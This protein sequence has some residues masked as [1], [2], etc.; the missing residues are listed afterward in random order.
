MKS[1]ERW[2]IF[3]WNLYGQRNRFYLPSLEKR[4]AFL[5]L[6]IG[7]WETAWRKE[8]GSYRQGIALS[9]ILTRIFCLAEFL[10]LNYLS[11][12]ALKY[13]QTGCAYC[14]QL[15]CVC[16]ERRADPRLETIAG[17]VQA[18]W[19]IGV[20][21][22]H[23]AAVYGQKNAA[24]GMNYLTGRLFRESCEIQSLFMDN[25]GLGRLTLLE[26][27]L[28]AALELSDLTAWSLGIMT[29]ANIDLEVVF[30]TRFRDACWKCGQNP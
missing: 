6:A 9:R 15:P 17:L 23:L 4:L 26:Q 21:A 11:A 1:L 16:R 30:T 24:Q 19:T 20:W 5:N 29:L 3:F 28:A 7:D 8:V 27:Q 14:G 12:M 10:D 13:P 18:N 25:E 2:M 22:N